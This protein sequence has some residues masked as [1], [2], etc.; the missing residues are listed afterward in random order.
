MG[1]RR[2]LWIFF[3]SLSRIVLLLACH[4][5]AFGQNHVPRT[6]GVLIVANHQSYLDP[7]YL[8]MSLDRSVS[9]MARRTLFENRAFN[10]LISNLNAFPVTRGG[11]DIAAMRE[12]VRRLEAGWCLLI[13]P[14]GTRSRTGEIAPIRAG[15]LAISERVRVP[16]VPAVVEGALAVWPRD[17]WPR[18]GRVCV[19][20]GRPIPPEE[21]AALSREELANRIRTELVNLQMRLKQHQARY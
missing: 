18:P 14:E 3:R 17:H 1:G 4:V 20:F 19:A 13:F 21:S 15:V 16:I 6:G 9:Y 12:S 10:W 11:L 8:G 7:V 2:L 5:R